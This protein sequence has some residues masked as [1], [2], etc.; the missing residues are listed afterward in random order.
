MILISLNKLLNK[1]SK[2]NRINKK[3]KNQINKKMS[4]KYQIIKLLIKKQNI[5]TK[6]Y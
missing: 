3:Y 4:K 6:T 2:Q 5:T 1:N